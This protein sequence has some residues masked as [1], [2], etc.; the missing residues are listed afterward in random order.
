MASEEL[1][2]AVALVMRVFPGSKIV[3]DSTAWS[4]PSKRDGR[5]ATDTRAS[6]QARIGS[7]ALSKGRPTREN[8]AK[9]GLR[10]EKL[11][12][13]SASETSETRRR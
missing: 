10:Q 4:K 13:V 6:P 3:R 7:Y 2:R 9:G 11:S 12:A 8:E 1:S 5:S